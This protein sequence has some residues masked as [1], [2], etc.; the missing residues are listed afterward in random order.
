MRFLNNVKTATLLAALLGLCML[1]GHFIGGP[2]GLTMGLLFGGVGS[3]I[4]FFFSDKMVIAATRAQQVSAESHPRLIA[5]VQQLAER[6]NLPM[7]RVYILPQQAP[8]A[9]ATGRSPKK[10]V[11][12]ISQGMLDYF[13]DSEIEGVMAHEL[14][15]I[16]HRDMLTATIAAVMAAVISYAGYM[17]FWF[18]G[19]GRS[20]NNPL[21]AVGAILVMILG[22]LAAGI[23]QMAISRQ[24]EYAADSYGGELCGDPMKLAN[25]LM[26]LKHGNERIPTETNPAFNS[27]YIA[28][29]FSRRAMASM[30]STHPP[31]EKRVAKLQAQA[32]GMR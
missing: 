26:R 17:F 22:P 12:A 30:F 20:D 4:S 5:M 13:P 27:L 6:A 10:S 15:H 8:N 25:A 19:G 24:R 32:A 14:A 3:V 18:G 21:G 7:P 2:R 9:F 28:Q 31:I 29:P 16:K 1:I 23:I 11:V